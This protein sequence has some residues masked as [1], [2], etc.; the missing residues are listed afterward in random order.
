MFGVIVPDNMSPVVAD[1][2]PM[3]PTLI[4]GWLDYAQA[5]GFGIDPARVR[6]PRDKPRVERVVQ[7]VRSNFF[8]GEM[9]VDVADA[10]R[11]AQMWCATT[12]G[13]RIHGTTGQRPIELFTEMEAGRLLP[14]PAGR[15]DVP[16]FTT[17]KVARDLHIEVARGFVFG[18][19]RAGRAT[20]AGAGRLGAGEGVLPWA[21]GQDP[22]RGTGRGP[23]PPTR[24]TTRWGAR[25]TRC[26]TWPP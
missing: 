22:P 4:P 21:A 19:R 15:Y 12:A 20:G 2:D 18:A 8:A 14:G 16:I 25:S 3:N 6:S 11:R 7:Y 13:L 5:R 9:F 24:R 10:Q 23:G 17:P 1:A 26:G